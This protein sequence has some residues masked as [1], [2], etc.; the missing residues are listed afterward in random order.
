MLHRTLILALLLTACCTAADTPAPWTLDLRDPA[1]RALKLPAGAAWS[2]EG[3]DGGPCFRITCDATEAATK[4]AVKIPID[5]TPWRGWRMALTAQVR[6]DQ[7]STGAVNWHGIKCQLH[8]RTPSGLDRWPEPGGMWGS[9]AWKEV[10]AM[11]PV[12]ADAGMGEIV[13]GMERTT[14]TA[15]IADVRLVPMMPQVARPAPAADAP[16][17][18]RGHDLPRLRGVMRPSRLAAE[19]FDDLKTWKVNVIRWRLAHS[20]GKADTDLDLAEYDRWLDGQLDELGKA[21]DLA[22]SR[23]IKL[24]PVLFNPPGGRL[25]ENTFRMLVEK[26]YQDHFI[27]SWQRIA[28]RFK[29]HPAV[30]AWNLVNE[31]VQNRPSPPGVLDWYGVQEAAARAIRA[32]DPEVP[33]SVEVDQWDGA[34]AYPWMRPIPLPRIIYQVHMYWP[35]AYTHQGVHNNW[36]V[37]GGSAAVAY[38]GVIQGAQAD[39]AAMMRHLQPARDFQKAYNVHMMVGEFSAVR[40]APGADRWLDDAISVF[41][42]WGW[43][44]CYHAFREWP[45]WSVEHADGPVDRNHHPKASAPTARAQVLR[46]WFDQNQAFP[47]HT[48]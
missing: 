27:A 10:S 21:L 7:V 26:R 35:H 6:A 47:I 13:L 2:D 43:D 48:P 34:E 30:W 4:Q 41:E 32:I 5:L 17:A 39:R 16:P 31:P 33:I 19:D 37:V 22:Q 14:G 25:V 3:P 9:F 8:W 12:D 20:W 1:V 45:G 18:F 42:E 23:G 15:W 44:W 46:R 11:A 40:W 36:G 28:T 29:G 38:P 24:M